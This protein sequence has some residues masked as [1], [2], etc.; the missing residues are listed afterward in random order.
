MLNPTRKIII[1]IA[2][3]IFSTGAL[4]P[5]FAQESPADLFSGSYTKPKTTKSDN[6]EEKPASDKDN[7]A[8][9][10]VKP[11][12]AAIKPVIENLTEFQLEARAY[13]NQGYDAQRRGD[14]QTAKAF[15]QKAIVLD[16]A[17]ASAYNDLGTVYESTGFPDAAEQNYLKAL[18]VDPSF[19]SAYSNLGLFYENKRDLK[20]AGYYWQKRAELGDPEDPWTKKAYARSYDIALTL[21]EIPVDSREQQILEMVKEVSAKKNLLKKDNVELSKDYFEKA[22]KYFQKGQDELALENATSASSLD[23]SNDKINE[24]IDKIRMRLLSR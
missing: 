15:Y 12:K 5:C 22:Q 19:L 17:L 1:T 21:G 13:R 14:I 2:V 3:V 23:P 18:K 9:K 20:K 6:K 8:D 24:F 10:K 4:V 16:P 11:K 7:K